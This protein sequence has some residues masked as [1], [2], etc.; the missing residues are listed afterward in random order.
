MQNV[1]FILTIIFFIVS[2]FI[3]IGTSI[4]WFEEDEKGYGFAALGWWFA[5]LWSSIILATFL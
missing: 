4:L 1:G 3:S 5:F 2:F